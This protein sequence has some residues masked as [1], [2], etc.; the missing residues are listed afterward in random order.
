MT[1]PCARAQFP[2]QYSA[3]NTIHVDDLSRNFALNS[4]NGLKVKA[5]KVR[6]SP[7][8]SA[9]PPR[10]SLTPARPP[11]GRPHPRPH[12]QR[13]GAPLRRALPPPSRRP[14]RPHAARPLALQKVQARA[15]R[16]RLGSSRARCTSTCAV[17]GPAFDDGRGAV[18]AASSSRST[19]AVSS[20]L[21]LDTLL[22]RF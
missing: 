22:P 15:P 19:A 18:A 11:A 10:P 2:G 1:D 14:R 9:L 5:Y 20:R 7:A 8:V 13:Q 16:R 17:A 4:K 12:E 6:T 21:A 3:A